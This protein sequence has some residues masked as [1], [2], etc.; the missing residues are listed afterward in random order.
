MPGK[1][2]ASFETMAEHAA[3]TQAMAAQLAGVSSF[4][5]SM[6]QGPMMAGL[7]PIGAPFVAAHMAATTN[8][9]ANTAELVACME[10]HGMA[11]DASS[12]SYSDTE[13]GSSDGFK[14]LI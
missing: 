3:Q 1:V 12:Q 13:G 2:G 7:G 8:H 6:F 9:M 10:A 14:S 5:P 11:V 4:D